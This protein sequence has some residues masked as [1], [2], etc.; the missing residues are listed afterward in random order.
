MGATAVTK[1]LLVE[2]DKNIAAGVISWLTTLHYTV[3]HVSDG[4]E[5]LERLKVCKY[6]VVVLDWG[7]PTISGP[8]ICKQYRS[9]QGKTPI[10]ML[11]AHSSIDDK[12]HGFGSGADDYL[13]KPFDPKELSVRIEALLRRPANLVADNLKVGNLELHP[14]DYCLYKNGT[15]IRLLP[16][17]FDLIKFLMRHPGQL[18]SADELIDRVWNS[19][20][21]VSRE[22]VKVYV[23]KIRRKI[24]V[25]GEPSIIAT[26]HGRGYRLDLAAAGVAEKKD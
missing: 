11:T 9:S 15:P 24:D 19:D 8:E 14:S 5:G 18:F 21:E 2:D 1:I 25:D 17:E 3:E 16:K 7:L 12:L 4:A 22:L 10:L 23:T 26:V 6:D 20:S 13:T